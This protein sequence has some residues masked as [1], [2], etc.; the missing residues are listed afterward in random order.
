VKYLVVDDHP[1]MRALLRQVLAAAADEFCEC[2]DGAEAIAAYRQCMAD[3]VLMDIE[4]P[5]LDGL[6]A[7]RR[8]CAEFPDARVILVTNHD[9]PE[10]R[11]QAAAFGALGYVTKDN[12]GS[13]RS[14][15]QLNR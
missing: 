15:L 2:A 1:R 11:Q 14:L 10:L 5:N 4:M 13:L 9:S 6:E 3:W 7:T 12:L 8:L